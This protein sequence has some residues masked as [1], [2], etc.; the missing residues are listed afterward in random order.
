MCP[1]PPH[2]ASPKFNAMVEEIFEK[3][4]K[5]TNTLV[6]NPSSQANRKTKIEMR[7]ST[8]EKGN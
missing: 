4:E 8:Q 5:L 3:L 7:T 1:P 2:L 6:M